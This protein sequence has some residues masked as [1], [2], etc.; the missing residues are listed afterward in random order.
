MWCLAHGNLS[1]E[2]IKTNHKFVL[3]LGV[4]FFL[5]SKNLV[6][7]CEQS[8]SKTGLHEKI[9]SRKQGCAELCVPGVIFSHIMAD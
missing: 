9:L 7:Y 6:I 1:Y 2:I 5:D 4:R 8:N 3:Y